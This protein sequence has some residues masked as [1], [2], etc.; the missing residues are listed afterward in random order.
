MQPALLETEVRAVQGVERVYFDI[1]NWDR[2]DSGEWAAR[3]R[4]AARAT[5]VASHAAPAIDLVG[6]GNAATKRVT[7]GT[8]K[9]GR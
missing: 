5:T 4:T 1:T 7:A 3:G 6:L 9:E 2:S 8:V